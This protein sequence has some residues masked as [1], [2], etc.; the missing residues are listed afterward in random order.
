MDKHFMPNY[1]DEPMR[2]FVL[3]LDEAIALLIPTIAL[4]FLAGS[5]LL[6]LAL[7]TILMLILKHIKGS[8][9]HYF[10]IRELYWRLPRILSN[11]LPPSHQRYYGG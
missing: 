5:L 11:H 4:F 3:T 10:L 8:N 6:G 7:G 9:G 1:L 2:I